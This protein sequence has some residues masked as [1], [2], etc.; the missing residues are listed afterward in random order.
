MAKKKDGHKVKVSGVIAKGDGTYYEE[1]DT[2]ENAA[3]EKSLK[4][5]GLI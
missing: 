1:G 3:D 2:I 5:K 4:E